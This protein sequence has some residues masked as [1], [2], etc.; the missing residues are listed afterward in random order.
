MHAIRDIVTV[1]SNRISYQLPVEF[2]GRKVE[3]IVLNMDEQGSSHDIIARQS[4]SSLRGALKSF[5][6]PSLMDSE[7]QAWEQ[8]AGKK[9]E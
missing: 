3:L 8:A 7:N 1:K 4:Q 6:N 9:H 2:S 5:A